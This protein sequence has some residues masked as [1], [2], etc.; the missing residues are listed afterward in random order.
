MQKFASELFMKAN[1]ARNRVK[2]GKERSTKGSL[3]FKVLSAGELLRLRG[4]S[5][6]A[7]MC[8]LCVNDEVGRQ[9]IQK[10]LLCRRTF[11]WLFKV[12][13]GTINQGCHS[14]LRLRNSFH[15]LRLLK[16]VLLPVRILEFKVIRNSCLLTKVPMP[17]SI[18]YNHFTDAIS[19]IH[20]TE[21]SPCNFLAVP[22]VAYDDGSITNQSRE[23]DILNRA[24]KKAQKMSGIK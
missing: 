2:L 3:D 10:G 20:W 14:F 16:E 15:A 5:R 6:V 23:R 12:R 4:C 17:R 8:I 7:S 22:S 9:E 19:T 11:Y 13:S 18:R 24:I 21:I 1:A